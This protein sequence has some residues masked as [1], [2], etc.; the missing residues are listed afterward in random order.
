MRGSRSFTLVLR[1]KQMVI[2]PAPSSTAPG[3]LRS[4]EQ[5]G[6]KGGGSAD[7]G[8]LVRELPLRARGSAAFAQTTPESTRPAGMYNPH[9]PR[10]IE[11]WTLADLGALPGSESDLFEFK[12]SAV[13]FEELPV[14]LARAAS[15]F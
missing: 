11:S 2:D 14:K 9:R 8:G 5:W 10:V 1:G 6:R 12:S 15:G 13:P 4:I 7:P 3:G